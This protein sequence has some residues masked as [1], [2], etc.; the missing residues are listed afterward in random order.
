[1]KLKTLRIQNFRGYKD[2][3]INFNDFNCIVGK[4]DVGKSTIFK[5]LEKFFDYRSDIDLNDYNDVIPEDTNEI[6]AHNNCPVILT[7]T[8]ECNDERLQPFLVNNSITI[9]KK[10]EINPRSLKYHY[11]FGI[12]VNDA[13]FG[14]DGF[15]AVFSTKTQ[16]LKTTFSINGTNYMLKPDKGKVEKLKDDVILIPT[17]MIY[18]FNLDILFAPLPK[19]KML[20]S[21]TEVAEYAQMYI[22]TL[23]AEEMKEFA[24]KI[25]NKL[26]P[27]FKRLFVAS[28]RFSLSP[29]ND[30]VVIDEPKISISGNIL[31]NI[32]NKK[33][34]LSNRGEG[35]QLNVRNVIFRHLATLSSS[36]NIIFAFEEP[37]AH[38]HPSAEQELY[39][40][41]KELS[42]NP[43][44][45]V[46]ITTHSPTIVSECS[47]KELIQ[48][49]H[50]N[51]KIEIKQDSDDVIKDAVEDLGITANSELISAIGFADLYL[52]V[53]GKHDVYFFN[54]V[55]QL[56]CDKK[57]ITDKI[58]IAPIPM[59]SGDNVN[60][61]VSLNLVDN[62]NKPY[63]FLIDS[64]NKRAKKEKQFNHIPKDRIHILRKREFEN[65]IKHS[66]IETVPPLNL[67]NGCLNKYVSMWDTLDVPL[68]VFVERN[69]INM[70]GLLEYDNSIVKDAANLDTVY[71]RKYKAKTNNDEVTTNAISDRS[72]YMKRIINEYLFEQSHI[73]KDDLDFSYTDDAGC[74]Q[75]EFLDIYHKIEKL[76]K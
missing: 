64:D 35:F 66:T 41:L 40:T 34:P 52:F 8:L 5:A 30:E 71:L 75:D 6:Y 43:N 63:L 72:E 76:C 74:L 54:H 22:E 11:H 56:Y 61:W 39:G 26:S 51:G 12:I 55:K 17:D 46:F 57:L 73:N 28:E 59:G 21:S 24:Q 31:T 60:L 36:E 20:S 3:T 68:V 27:E 47:P 2:E 65:Y 23:M 29:N 18:S 1:M 48:V 69:N 37:E 38:L 50:G 25:N 62:L 19:F 45:Q 15:N 4:N 58:K 16:N 33:I 9:Q 53:E 70:N 32:G 42:N 49:K 67:S 10:Y 13:F 14:K 7:A 44:Y